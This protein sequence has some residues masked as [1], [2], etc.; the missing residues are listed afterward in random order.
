M[1]T[2]STISLTY[3]ATSGKLIPISPAKA[4]ALTAFIVQA[5]GKTVEATFDIMDS[6]EHFQHKYLYGYCYGPMAEASGMDVDEIDHTMKMKYLRR[7][8]GDVM[9][10][11]SRYRGKCIIV[12]DGELVVAYVPSKAS[13]TFAEYKGYIEMVEQ[14]RDGLTGWSIPDHEAAMDIRAKA[15]GEEVVR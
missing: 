4:T 15:M 14:E 10:I 8:V 2:T 13:L 12:M 5:D 1:K 11:P 7:N 9:Q 3:Q 6:V